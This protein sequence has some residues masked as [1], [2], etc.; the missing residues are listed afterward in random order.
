MYVLHH[1]DQPEI[2][3]GLPANPSISPLVSVW[4]GAAKVAGIM[5]IGATVIGALVHHIF[6][7]ANRVSTTFPRLKRSHRRSA[8]WRGIARDSRRFLIGRLSR[9][10]KPLLLLAVRREVRDRL[11]LRRQDCRY[12]ARSAA[13]DAGRGR[14]LRGGRPPV[15]AP[16][17]VDP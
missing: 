14:Y 2:Y 12:R 16:L 10:G 7:G 15:R 3:A 9:I 17:G 1:A 11:G 6:A 5:A 4:K 8:L 13:P